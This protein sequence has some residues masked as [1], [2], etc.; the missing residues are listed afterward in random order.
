M[1]WLSIV[2]SVLGIIEGVLNDLAP[3]LGKEAT[4]AHQAKVNVTRMAAQ[5]LAAQLQT[6]TGSSN[7]PA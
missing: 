2:E 5:D 6:S 7:P 4:N 1:G 3:I